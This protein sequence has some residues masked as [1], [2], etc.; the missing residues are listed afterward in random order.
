M[1]W[2]QFPALTQA[3]LPCSLVCFELRLQHA[4]EALISLSLGFTR[5]GCW[6]L[7]FSNTKV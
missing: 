1:G 2:L 4:A 3:V 7:Y 5:V 6:A